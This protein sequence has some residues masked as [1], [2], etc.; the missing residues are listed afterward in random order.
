MI[1]GAR[2]NDGCGLNSEMRP[3]VILLVYFAECPSYISHNYSFLGIFSRD[4]SEP[5]KPWGKKERKNIYKSPLDGFLFTFKLIKY[6]SLFSSQLLLALVLQVKGARNI[7]EI[8][9]CKPSCCLTLPSAFPFLVT[10]CPQSRYSLT[11]KDFPAN[12]I[13]HKYLL[14]QW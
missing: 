12:S 1:R 8:S 2:E 14:W 10:L 13:Y 11:D 9:T 6:G 3:L 5:V 4:P 7:K